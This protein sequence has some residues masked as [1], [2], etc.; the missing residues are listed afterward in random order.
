[1]FQTDIALKGFG[2]GASLIIAIGAQNAFVLRQ[3]LRHAAPFLTALTCAV[4][5]ALL[6]AAGLLGAGALVNAHP[7]LARWAAALGAVFLGVYGLRALKAALHPGQLAVDHGAGVRDW[8]KVIATTLGFSLLNPHVYLDTVVLLGG[9]GSQFTASGGR[10]SFGIGAT[11]A[12]FCWFFGLAYGAGKLAPLFAK[13]VAWRVLDVL[14]GL[15][16][17]SL[18]ISLARAAWLG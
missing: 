3:G 14:I 11:T 16:M 2:L 5:D 8:R 13:Q 4:C 9:I 17:S 1:M 6:I 18:A 10:L 7:G 15:T 12:S